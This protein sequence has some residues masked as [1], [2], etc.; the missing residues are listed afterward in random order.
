MKQD[1]KEQIIEAIDIVDYI[2]EAVSLRRRGANFVGLCPF[3]QE[4][5]PS[6]T[7]SP[8]K[9]IFKCFGCGKSGNVITFA[10]EY[11]GLSYLEAIKELAKR[12]GLRYEQITDKTREELSKRD[13]IYQAL[14]YAK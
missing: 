7:V 6:F 11:Y 1:L 3:H 12:A 14:E 9:K 13:R 4:K 8:E 5:T 2:G 10:V